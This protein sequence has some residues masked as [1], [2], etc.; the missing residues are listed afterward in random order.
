MTMF[1][2]MLWVILGEAVAIVGLL[3]ECHRLE[4]EYEHR[5]NNLQ[6]QK[7]GA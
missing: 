4:K 2:V 1:G 5:L 3:A 6:E 7:K